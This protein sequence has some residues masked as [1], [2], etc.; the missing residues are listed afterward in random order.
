MMKIVVQLL[1]LSLMSEAQGAFD[2]ACV[3]GEFRD[4]KDMRELHFGPSPRQ[5]IPIVNLTLG[6]NDF[7]NHFVTH[8]LN[9]KKI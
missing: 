1:A 4:Q 2:K 7:R 6:K 9:L 5:K 8:N 3:K